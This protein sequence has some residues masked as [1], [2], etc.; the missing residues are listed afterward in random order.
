MI[1]VD[2]ASSVWC[3]SFVSPS[4]QN[5][6]DLAAADRRFRRPGTKQPFQAPSRFHHFLTSTTL[7]TMS[8]SLDPLWFPHILADILHNTDWQTLLSSRLVSTSMLRLVDPML[9]GPTLHLQNNTAGTIEAISWGGDLGGDYLSARRVPYFYRNGSKD[10]RAAA[11]RKVRDLKLHTDAATEHVNLLL[12]LLPPHAKIWI[13]HDKEVFPD[14]STATLNTTIS[15]P[16]CRSLS[17][18]VGSACKCQGA[19]F[20]HVAPSVTFYPYDWHYEEEETSGTRSQCALVDGVL[21]RGV[22]ELH[23]GADEGYLPKLFKDVNLQVNPELR[24]VLLGCEDYRV[25]DLVK[26]RSATAKCFNIPESQVTIRGV[27][28]N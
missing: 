15:L 20:N 27:D 12:Q 23:V 22:Y 8:P 13:E 24:V 2:N 17:V 11:I 28:F 3:Y 18:A 5:A 21:N 25:D 4:G 1:A 14:R 26:T 6:S 19:A 16:P 7:I 9:C 10:S